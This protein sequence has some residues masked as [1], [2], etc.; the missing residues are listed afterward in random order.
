MRCALAAEDVAEERIVDF[1]GGEGL[2]PVFFP[3]GGDLARY[4]GVDCGAVRGAVSMSVSVC[5]LGDGVVGPVDV[6][7]EDAGA[8]PLGFAHGGAQVGEEPV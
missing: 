4:D 7:L 6:F 1:R 3:G 5:V 2:R 8:L